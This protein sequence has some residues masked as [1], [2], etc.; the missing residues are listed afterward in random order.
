MKVLTYPSALRAQGSEY[1]CGGEGGA[2]RGRGDSG[3]RESGGPFSL[4]CIWPEAVYAGLYGSQVD[5][6][7]AGH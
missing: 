6:A 1:G 7:Q 5:K 2:G 4:E 3:F